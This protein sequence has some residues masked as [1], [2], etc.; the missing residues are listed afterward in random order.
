MRRASSPASASRCR[1]PARGRVPKAGGH[2]G[3]RLAAEKG[4][5]ASLDPTSRAIL[6]DISADDREHAQILRVLGGPQSPRSALDLILKKERHVSGAG[7]VSDA[8][9]GQRR[10]GAVFGIVSGMAGYTGGSEIVLITG[11]AGTLASALSMGSSA[12]LAAKSQREVYQGEIAGRR[13]RSST[14]PGGTGGTGVVLPVEGFTEE[15]ARTLVARIREQPEDFLK[16]LVQEELG[17][18]EAT[19]PN[20]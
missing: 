1:W 16:T 8:I 20:P 4:V 12:Y 18:S 13:P 7:W 5:A 9:Y 6:E 11:L 2:G 3:A 17:L 19:F 14:I 15:E 10:L